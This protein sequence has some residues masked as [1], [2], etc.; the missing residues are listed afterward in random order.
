MEKEENMVQNGLEGII[1]TAYGA[2]IGSTAGISGYELY[3]NCAKEGMDSLAAAGLGGVLGS[4]ILGVGIAAA[5]PIF[6]VIIGNGSL[7][8]GSKGYKH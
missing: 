3:S 5:Y 4:A 6:D 7:G 1:A 8:N 2:I